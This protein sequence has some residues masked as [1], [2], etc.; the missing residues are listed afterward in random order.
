VGERL[1]SLLSSWSVERR[2]LIL[3]VSG[4][5]ALIFAAGLPWLK[6]DSSPDALVSTVEG[7]AEVEARFRSH[8]PGSDTQL[9]VI[10]ESP[11][12]TRLEEIRYQRRLSRALGRERG[13]ARVDS[14]TEV[15]LAPATREIEELTD[16]QKAGAQVQAAVQT[17]EEARAQAREEASGP[18]LEAEVLEAIVEGDEE[19]F[20]NGLPELATRLAQ[21]A[22]EESGEWGKKISK[23]EHEEFLLR[24]GDSPWVT[25]LLVSLDRKAAALV[26]NFDDDLVFDQSTRMD[27]LFRLR[28][29]V[30]R[31][32]RPGSVEVK[33]GGVPVLREAIL[34][35]LEKDR[36]TLNPAMMLVCL[37]VLWLTFR[38]W[39]AVVGPICAVGIA[40]L[41]VI[42]GMAY[43]GVS[44]T[45]LTNIIPPLL[46]I[47]G[48]SDSV[49][50]LGRYRE[51]L[52][53][54]PDR[55]SAGRRAARAMLVACFL[56]SLTTAVGF[57]SLA[58]AKTPELGRFGVAAALGVVFAYFAT[59]FF[60]PAFVTKTPA[61]KVSSRGEGHVGLLERSVFVVTRHVLEHAKWVAAGAVV[62]TG[63]LVWG[64]TQVTVDARLLDAFEKGEEV[65]RTTRFLE[66]KLSGI[67][68]LEVMITVEDGSVLNPAVIERV[69]SVTTWVSGEKNVIAASNFALPLRSARQAVTGD[70]QTKL[71]P[72][73]SLEHVQA[74]GE[75]LRLGPTDPLE[76][77]VSEDER[78]ARMT[79]FFEDAGIRRT[80][81]LLEQLGDRL[82]ADRGPPIK[83]DF[84][85]EAYTGSVGRD[86]VLRDLIS[87]LALALGLIFVLLTLLFR[88]LRLGLVAMPPNVIPLFATGAYMMARGIHLN[89]ATVIT[90]SIGIGLAVDDTVHVVA[91]FRE[92]KKRITSVRVALLRAARGTGRAI[93]VTAVSLSLGFA[94]LMMSE[95][96]S[97]RQFGELIAVTVIN[98]LI[99]AL[100]IQPAL[101]LLVVGSGWKKD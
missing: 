33:L 8:F 62:L 75:V 36:L 64:A 70:P 50:L 99:S 30:E 21:G 67:R 73:D 35:K 27:L 3:I 77:W 84:L 22:L 44:L 93:V 28:G 41:M 40:A 25:P 6:V 11:D 58:T 78:T 56:T 87:G 60:V 48:L 14:L 38:W 54:D 13:V 12:V 29:V 18:Q 98:C 39:P 92:E 46:I 66:E 74:L 7:Q 24:L 72:F 90:F 81:S 89:M 17:Q 69:E 31:E 4:V 61:P 100:I 83:V 34:K 96:V 68:P 45:I 49:H 26:V 97:V 82:Q 32:P 95:F 86:D 23:E 43:L 15:G 52:E 85:G 5:V 76:N 16:E 10:L 63:G 42:G 88:S 101:L 19:S 51:E 55:I 65:T 9:L 2:G 53:F 1:I 20:P 94:V 79:V 57:G 59:V 47:V 71:R 91:R 37:L 80:L